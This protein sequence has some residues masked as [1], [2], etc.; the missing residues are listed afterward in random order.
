[1]GIT[2]ILG[3]LVLSILVFFHEFGH[4]IVA[5]RSHIV[6]EEFGFG[7]PPRLLKL[8]ERGG[9]EFTLNAIPFGGFCRMLG[10]DD[11]TLPGSFAAASKRAR[12]ATLFAGAGMN[13][14][15]AILLFGAYA[16]MIG[17]PDPTRP[18]TLVT[19]IAP[20]SPAAAA[21]LQIGD[22]IISANGLALPTT[23]DLQRDT[24][25]NAGHPVTYQVVRTDRQKGTS[26]TLEYTLTPRANPPP[27]QGALGIAITQ[28][29]RPVAPWVALWRGVSDTWDVILSTFQVPVML[30]RQGKPIGDAGFM[31]PVG[32]TVF[33]G[34]FVRSAASI[35]ALAPILRFVA[36]LSAALGITQLLPIPALD[37][38][39]LLFILVEVIRGKRVSPAQEG[40]VHLIGFGLLLALIGV[41]TIREISS[42]VMGTFPTVGIR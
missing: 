27:N 14:L 5:K 34:E 24:A 4:F 36:L 33:A 25:A 23:Q 32:I 40:M 31:G 13:F 37:G 29:T 11:P 8:G 12:A 20:G 15:L 35:S 26:S 38:G 19:A 17:E 6:V 42:M 9:T 16:L 2:V 18:G 1:M 21:G 10:E 30:L 22:R 28:A 39:R 41:V 7:F 3:V